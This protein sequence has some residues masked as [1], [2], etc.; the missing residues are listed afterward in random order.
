[1]CTGGGCD[2]REGDG[3]EGRGAFNM[4]VPGN[5]KAALVEVG[6]EVEV[7]VEVEVEVEVDVEVEIEVEVEVV[8]EVEVEVEV[9]VEVEEGV[10]VETFQLRTYCSVKNFK[11]CS[12]CISPSPSD[13][14]FDMCSVYILSISRI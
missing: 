13:G 6:L 2:G 10:E 7:D 12:P 4:T 9:G 11:T 14:I 8:V 5:S 1:V 3:G